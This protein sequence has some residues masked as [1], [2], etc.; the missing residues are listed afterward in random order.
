MLFTNHARPRHDIVT[1]LVEVHLTGASVPLA[2][3]IGRIDGER[4]NP[5]RRRR[6]IDESESPS[7][8]QMEQREAA[9]RLVKAPLGT[10]YE[11]RGIRFDV[12][13]PPYVTAAVTRELAPGPSEAGA[14]T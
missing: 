2:A 7:C 9:S 8:A 14:A 1:R 3:R 12:D 13:L 6:E 4:A 11:S 10:S 5:R